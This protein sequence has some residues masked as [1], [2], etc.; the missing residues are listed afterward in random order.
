MDANVLGFTGLIGP[1]NFL[2]LRTSFNT[3][4]TLF[5]FLWPPDNGG[6]IA[7]NWKIFQFI[8]PDR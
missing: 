1:K 4:T 8:V 5:A 2:F 3:I 6:I 7:L